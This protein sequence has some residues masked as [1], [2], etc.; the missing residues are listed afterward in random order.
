MPIISEAEANMAYWLSGDCQ[1]LH[2]LHYTAFLCPK[3]TD[4][5]YQCSLHEDISKY[6]LSYLILMPLDLNQYSRS[7]IASTGYK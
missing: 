4:R 2:H 3:S 7:S 6:V 5:M 1:G